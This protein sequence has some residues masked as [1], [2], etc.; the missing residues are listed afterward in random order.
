MGSERAIPF[1]RDTGHTVKFTG[2]R[3]SACGTRR[4][5][6]RDVSAPGLQAAGFVARDIQ[7]FEHLQVRLNLRLHR[8]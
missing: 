8:P 6:I 1:G 2:G 4:G 5:G 3:G 7:I